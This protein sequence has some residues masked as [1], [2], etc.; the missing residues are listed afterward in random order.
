[1]V[2]QERIVNEFLELVQID[3]ETT[4]E[5]NIA[6]ALKEKFS[7]LGL[8]VYE[9]DTKEKT[10]HGAGNLFCTL[11]A[12]KQGIDPIYFTC[13]MDTVVPGNG[14]KPTIKDGYIV[15]DGTTIL[16]ALLRMEQPF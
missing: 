10:G 1:M 16:G 4:Q 7:S 12:N 8:E 13:H 3:S 14:I 2:N 5:T 15:T 6:K 9:D 11:K